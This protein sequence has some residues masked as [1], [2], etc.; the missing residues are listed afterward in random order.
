MS[1]TLL[2]VRQP[3]SSSFVILKSYK[4]L[5]WGIWLGSGVTTCGNKTSVLFSITLHSTFTQLVHFICVV[6]KSLCFRY[7][8]NKNNTTHVILEES[9]FRNHDQLINSL[10]RGS[11]WEAISSFAT[12]Q[13][14]CNLWNLKVH[15]CVKNSPTLIPICEP[16]QPSPHRP[17]LF[18]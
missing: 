1:D 6:V 3:S 2:K 18:L 11:S 14:P 9:S 15:C 7:N 16:D 8:T 17:S 10:Q 4:A 5:H 12:Q 13:I